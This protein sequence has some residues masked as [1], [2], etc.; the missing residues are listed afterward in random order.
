MDREKRHKGG[1][2]ILAKNNLPAKHFQVDTNQQAQI[3]GITITVRKSPITVYNLYCPPDK[4]LSLQT[5]DTPTENCLTV[6]DF[7]SHST[8]WGYRETDRRGDEVED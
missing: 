1:V 8:S 7:N 3:H 5:L 6:A 4:N 2:L